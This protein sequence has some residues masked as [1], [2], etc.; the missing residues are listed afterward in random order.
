MAKTLLE[1]L[2]E[3]TVVVADTGDFESIEQFKPQ[4]TTT[5]PSLL[6]AAAQ[7]PQYQQ[8]VDDVLLEARK[9]LGPQA[10]DGSNTWLWPLERRSWPSCPGGFLPKSTPGCR[11]TPPQP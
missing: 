2:R 10:K 5:N 11:T 4:D 7:M 8:I 6:T 1:Q 9:Q 3:M